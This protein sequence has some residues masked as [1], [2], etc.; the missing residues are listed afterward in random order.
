MAGTLVVNGGRIIRR[1]VG[2]SPTDLGAIELAEETIH[3]LRLTPAGPLATYYLGSLPFILGLLYFWADMSRGAF[4]HEYA[5][6]ASLGLAL[7]FI[8]MKFWQAVFCRRLME[9]L[10]GED[11]QAHD[12][13][14][15][16]RLI[17]G[18][19]LFQA[20]GLFVLPVALVLVFPLAWVYAYYQ[21]LTVLADGR[22]KDLK[23]SAGEAW[24]MARLWAR[25]NHLFLALLFLFGLFVFLNLAL[26]L[27][28]VPHL[29]NSL[30][31]IETLFTLSGTGYLNTTFWAVC[32][33]LTYLCLDPLVKAAYT[34]RCF[35][36]A[37]LQTGKDLKVDLSR[38][39]A[40]SILLMGLVV[41]GPAAEAATSAPAPARSSAGT[42]HAAALTPLD[43]TELERSISE[44]ISRREFAWRLPQEK[45]PVKEE[46]G[47][48]AD[49][50][51]WLGENT[52]AAAK[53]V[54]RWLRKLSDWLDSLF[55]GRDR[56]G[57]PSQPK[58]DSFLPANV[59]L[60]ALLA[61]SA[62]ALAILV[63]R[64]WRKSRA[65]PVAVAAPVQA[66]APDLEDENLAA[67]ALPGDGWLQLA[68]E[69]LGRGE[70]RLA[71]RAFYL[72]TLARLAEM[73]IIALAK[74]KSNHEYLLELGRRTGDLPDV[75][76]SFAQNIALFDA[77]WYGRRQPGPAEIDFF[78]L[79]QD[80]IIAQ[81]RRE[82]SPE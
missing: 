13:S 1:Q 72:A 4:A 54:R 42:H 82:F 15:T 60:Y 51:S 71:L 57:E 44:V 52:K 26:A 33:A 62:S 22:D 14:R 16:A 35:R 79:N 69:L 68:H 45:P 41:A 12:P 67:D 75:R 77:V 78:L 56:F 25:P 24:H 30:L 20:S 48:L 65:A 9:R 7:L 38:L 37:S 36:G 8:W 27:Y 74:Y 55:P 40:A 28:M 5:A 73:E 53:A 29:L 43:T 80:L 64:T 46:T 31:G 70:M 59:L 6:P 23:A 50:F 21:N 81:L 61:L 19:A 17:A 47:L 34:L 3:L 63:W 10:S 58:S 76:K 66:A 18:Q 32:A 11:Q 49:V 39:A 2:R